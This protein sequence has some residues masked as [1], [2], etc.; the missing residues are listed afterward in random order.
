MIVTQRPRQA[1]MPSEPCRHFCATC[2]LSRDLICESC[3]FLGNENDLP[4]QHHEIHL[5]PRSIIPPLPTSVF[6]E[7]SRLKAICP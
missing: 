5:R 6:E 4:S 7:R 3:N 2:Q 1:A